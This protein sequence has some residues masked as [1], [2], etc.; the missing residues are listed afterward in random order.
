MK[1]IILSVAVSKEQNEALRVLSK[2]HGQTVSNLVRQGINLIL[3]VYRGE[4]S[5]KCSLD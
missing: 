4:A 3:G 1:T 5:K 2:L